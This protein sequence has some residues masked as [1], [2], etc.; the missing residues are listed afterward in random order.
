MEKWLSLS[1]QAS[2]LSLRRFHAEYL[3]WNIL[4]L[5]NLEDMINIVRSDEDVLPLRVHSRLNHRLEGQASIRF[6]HEH[7]ELIQHHDW[8]LNQTSHSR[9]QTETS[10]WSFT[11]AQHAQGLRGCRAVLQAGVDRDMKWILVIINLQV[12]TIAS[13]CYGVLKQLTSLLRTVRV[14]YTLVSLPHSIGSANGPSL[15]FWQ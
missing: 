8:R 10:T 4:F 14:Q 15:L 11:S 12:S 1:S 2:S 9:N 3:V 6:V 5:H 13:T 7:I